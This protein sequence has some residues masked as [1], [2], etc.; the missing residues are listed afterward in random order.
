VLN[1]DRDFFIGSNGLDARFTV[2]RG[3]D[4]GAP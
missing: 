1:A 4:G 2:A 3:G